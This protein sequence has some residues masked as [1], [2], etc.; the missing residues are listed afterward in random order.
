MRIVPSTKKDFAYV[1]FDER[2][3]EEIRRLAEKLARVM[4][5]KLRK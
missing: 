1:V 3:L 4:F 5:T 2:D